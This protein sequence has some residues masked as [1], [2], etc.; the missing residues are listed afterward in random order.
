MENTNKS[1]VYWAPP[2]EEFA[3]KNDAKVMSTNNLVKARLILDRILNNIKSGDNVAIKVH[4]GEAHNTHYLRHDYISEVV[5]A[6]KSKGAVPTLIET[7]GLGLNIRSLQINENYTICLEHRKTGSNH[8]KIAQEHGY[9]ESIVGAPLEF[10]DGENGIDEKVVE[11]DGIHFKKVSVGKGLFKFD[12]MIVVSHFKGHPQ[13]TFGGALKQVGIGCVTKKNKHLAHF[14]DLAKINSK[15]CDISKCK[16][17][18]V[19]SCPVSAISLGVKSAIIDDSKCYGC[20]SCIKKCPIKRAI[21]EPVLN[22]IKDYMEKVLD[23]ALAVTSAFGPENIRYLNFAMDVTLF[24]D[25]VS[26]ANMPIVPDLGVFG[27]SDPVAVDRACIDA[28]IN[29]PGL[30][31]FKNG[32]WTTPLPSG[33]EKFKAMSALGGILDSKFQFEAA[34]RNKI[35]NTNYELIKI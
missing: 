32:G 10:V 27:S 19:K 30:P 9:T 31:I 6:V 3:L 24:C 25:C 13:A 4:V 33:V 12:K 34:I 7:Q 16:Q 21:V 20:L 28:E 11:I 1:I 8:Q 14:T 22:D 15:K 18:C 5:K 35:G 2:N 23:N 29:A 17:E 26:N